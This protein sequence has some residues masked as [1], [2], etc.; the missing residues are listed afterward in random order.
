MNA[1]IGIDTSSGQGSVALA[2]AQGEALKVLEVVPIRG[3]TFSA[4]LVPQLAELL[5]RHDVDKTELAGIAAATGPGSF[6]G[7]RVGLAAVKGLAEVLNIP[8]AKVTILEAM[9]AVSAEEGRVLAALDAGRGEVYVGDYKV[10][11]GTV[12]GREKLLSQGE[13][14]AEVR[15]GQYGTV[16]VAEDGLATRLAEAEIAHCRVE[17]PGSAAVARLGWQK[18]RTGQRVTSEELDAT[19]IRRSDAEIFSL[20]RIREKR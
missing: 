12:A 17:R 18:L 3:G 8:V 6:T 16:L 5:K 4:Q 20:P 14:V 11:S 13:L 19:Y 1:I 9:A 7:L 15:S 2:H 10:A